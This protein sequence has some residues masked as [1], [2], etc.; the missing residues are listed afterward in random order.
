MDAKHETIQNYLNRAKM[1]LSDKDWER[2]NEYAEK[3]LDMDF[4]FAEAYLV[5]VLCQ[6][7]RSKLDEAKNDYDI[8]SNNDFAKA[9]KFA[10]GSFKAQLN[11]FDSEVKY[12]I[13][14]DALN[15]DLTEKLNY[16]KAIK[17]LNIIK[18]YKD[19]NEILDELPEKRSLLLK[20]KNYNFAQ[21]LLS[22]NLADDKV[23][24]SIISYLQKAGDFKDAE[25]LLA[26]IPLKRQDLIDSNNYESAVA[27]MN[28]DLTD[29]TVYNHVVTCL[30]NSNGY[31]DAEM[32]LKLLP[33]KRKEQQNEKTYKQALLAVK[34]DLTVGT[35]YDTAVRLLEEIKGYKN[36][37]AMLDSL[38]SQKQD[39][40]NEKTYNS[41]LSTL[42]LDL[43]ISAN[44]EKA[45]KLLKSIKGYKDADKLLSD[46]PGKKR[47]QE[48]MKAYDQALV[49]IKRD[50][51]IESNYDNAVRLLNKASGYKD[52]NSI[53]ARIT[54]EK[55]ARTNASNRVK[56][57]A[58]FGLIAAIAA[59]VCTFFVGTKQT[60]LFYYF[61]SA[62]DRIG[63]NNGELMPVM[64][65]ISG[66]LFTLAIVF[67]NFLFGIKAIVQNIKGIKSKSSH[68]IY[69]STKSVLMYLVF[70]L[71][72]VSVDMTDAS[73]PGNANPINFMTVF[74]MI[75]S[76]GSLVLA[77]IFHIATTKS[78]Y[79]F[80]HNKGFY[81]TG[82]IR[83][84]I[85]VIMFFVLPWSFT[86]RLGSDYI[87]YTSF[88]S[89]FF[90]MINGDIE[91]GVVFDALVGYFPMMMMIMMMLYSSLNSLYEPCDEYSKKHNIT[92]MIF[93]FLRM[94]F[95]VAIIGGTSYSEYYTM[96]FGPVIFVLIASIVA[97]VF[98]IINCKLQENV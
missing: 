22:G 93:A 25:L 2:A 57:S 39:Q 31:K 6:Y 54:N 51:T 80:K 34:K 88:S 43:T 21:S 15:A 1:F 90:P 13:A 44:Y 41:A 46:L 91:A 74:G 70:A 27:A 45:Q 28:K 83:L 73:Y 86:I 96:E 76:L 19:V 55:Q 65:N 95:Q 26:Q 16:D 33:E 53:L 7:K 94:I 50:L 84:V 85:T 49:A 92:F 52:A 79:S 48:R 10:S 77:I 14:M 63:S 29:D 61:S 18:G 67:F 66:I 37:D 5:K 36:A 11:E 23:Y 30:H 60:H 12:Q 32:L 20:E 62:W 3:I 78:R 24:N 89:S 56:L 69:H 64:A 87:S 82:F 71:L 35:N 4:E 17:C 58:I 98:T 97:L 75:V 59:F 68:G 40:T 72:F 42:K 8:V 9:V 81:V 38:P 47:T